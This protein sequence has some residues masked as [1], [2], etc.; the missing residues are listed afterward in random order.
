MQAISPNFVLGVS[1]YTRKLTWLLKVRIETYGGL[2]KYNLRFVY[3]VI[4]NNIHVTKK[5][6]RISMKRAL[7]CSK[8]CIQSSN[9]AKNEAPKQERYPSIKIHP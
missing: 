7:T 5:M 4:P 6:T 2:P 3:S 9:Y 1:Q 8:E